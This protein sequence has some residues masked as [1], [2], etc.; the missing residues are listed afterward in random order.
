LETFAPKEGSGGFV[1][2]RCCFRLLGIE[3]TSAFSHSFD[4]VAGKFSTIAFVDVSD[5]GLEQCW[6][7]RPETSC[8]LQVSNG[9]LALS[10]RLE[11]F[12]PKEG[13]GGFVRGDGSIDLI[14]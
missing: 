8:G 13:S 12:A 11:T 6:V 5:S 3:K 14:G 2:S 10:Q 4:I 1:I 7:L 9:L